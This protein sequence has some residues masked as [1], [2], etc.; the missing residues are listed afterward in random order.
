M[1]QPEWT[2]GDAFGPNATGASISLTAAPIGGPGP[3]ALT[4][5]AFNPGVIMTAAPVPNG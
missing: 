1:N 3:L 4:L 2:R 5:R